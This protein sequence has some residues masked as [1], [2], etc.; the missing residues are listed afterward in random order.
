MDSLFKKAKPVLASS[1]DG[2]VIPVLIF[3]MMLMGTLAVAAL[4]TSG[5][6]YR[7]SRAMRESNE[8]FYAAEAGL[9]EV[10]ANWDSSLVSGLGPSDSVDLGWQTLQGGAGY[11]IIIHRYH[12]D[13]EESMYILT[14]EGRG[15]LGRSSGQRLVSL[16]ITGSPPVASPF[17]KAAIVTR[18]ELHFGADD[19]CWNG[20]GTCDTIPG[21][22]GYRYN[23]ISW[24]S[25]EDAAPNGWASEACE[26]PVDDLPD[27]IAE[28][29][30]DVD[31]H[32]ENDGFHAQVEGGP[33]SESIDW[34]EEDATIDDNTFLEFG[35]L[36]RQ[37]LIDMADH[38]LDP[39]D[40]DGDYGARLTAPSL[41]ADGTCNT[42]DPYNW[43]SPDP[44][45]ACYNYFPIIHVP[46]GAE[47]RPPKNPAEGNARKWPACADYYGQAI[48][49]ATG[50]LKLGG[51]CA[52]PAG[53]SID[54]EFNGVVIV[55]GCLELQYSTK[56][57]GTAYVDDDMSNSSFPDGCDVSGGFPENG[58]IANQNGTYQFS[59]CAI[60]RALDAND[61]LE[62]GGWRTL[63]SRAFFEV[64]R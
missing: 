38:V 6:E 8:A 26:D 44:S 48:I 27:I 29:E 7:S 54:Y 46:D 10:W 63:S 62:E 13:G 56:F 24:V 30:D 47:I 11:R 34:I 36:T 53:G 31:T 55:E 17:E 45:H 33:A 43:G 1:S 32:A 52:L 41:N 39:W 15:A 16:S 14:A 60:R 5:D 49:V 22:Y 9:N 25:G 12:D 37:D 35:N 4:V 40:G 58:V 23:D 61:I 28:D 42:D 19:R 18:G 57:N 21:S 50:P 20:T 64:V 3:V 2:F 51:S 59:S